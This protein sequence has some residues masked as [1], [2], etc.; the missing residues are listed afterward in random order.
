M[1]GIGSFR[2]SIKSVEKQS[3]SGTEGKEKRP[4]EGIQVLAIALFKQSES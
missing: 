2:S 4:S 3:V 1:I